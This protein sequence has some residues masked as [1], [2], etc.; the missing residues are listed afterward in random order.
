MCTKKWS[1]PIGFSWKEVLSKVKEQLYQEED[2]CWK[3]RPRETKTWAAEVSKGQS[4][5]EDEGQVQ[6]EDHFSQLC[7]YIYWL[8]A[9]NWQISSNGF[10]CLMKILFLP[11]PEG[12][13]KDHRVP[14]LREVKR[15]LKSL[16]CGSREWKRIPRKYVQHKEWT[17]K[18]ET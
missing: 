6:V 12:E 9:K 14:S 18:L 13:I 1:T 2:R 11:A 7:N 15:S 3:T 16:S 5:K 17:R 4:L 10:C 8:V